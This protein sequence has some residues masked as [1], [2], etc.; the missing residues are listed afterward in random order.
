MDRV[1][2]KLWYSHKVENY[3]AV[4][5]NRLE[6]HVSIWIDLTKMIEAKG[7]I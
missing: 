5:M 1:M 7:Y 6:L 3:I 2:Y 4:K